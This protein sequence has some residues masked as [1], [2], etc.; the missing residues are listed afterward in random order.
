[1]IS[2][3]TFVS[4]VCVGQAGFAFQAVPFVGSNLLTFYFS[5]TLI[6]SL[7]VFLD[8]SLAKL[9]PS[10]DLLTKDRK[11]FLVL[12]NYSLLLS[13][14]AEIL[15]SKLTTDIRSTFLALFLS[16]LVISF[17]TSQVSLQYSL[18]EVYTPFAPKGKS[19]LIN[20]TVS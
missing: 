10:L 4:N 9:L 3:L 11:Y 2:G 19:L 20:K 5:K 17:L 16:S 8:C 18:N 15:S 13:F 12:F 7:H 1:M 6:T 14:T